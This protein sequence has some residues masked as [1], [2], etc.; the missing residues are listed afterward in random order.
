MRTT[1]SVAGSV[2]LTFPLVA[3][4]AND[5]VCGG[6]AE[7]LS[8]RVTRLEQ[9]HERISK[10]R[11]RI[12]QRCDELQRSYKAIQLDLQRLQANAVL[13]TV[14]SVEAR[15]SRDDATRQAEEYASAHR[16]QPGSNANGYNVRLATSLGY[17][18]VQY[19]ALAAGDQ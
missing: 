8:A 6:S 10:E 3:L 11:D 12:V 9:R 7:D 1:W 18:A 2:V 5:S 13:K 16:R 17:A 19:E 14:Q 15:V 4:C